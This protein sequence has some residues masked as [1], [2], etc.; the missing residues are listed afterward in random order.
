MGCILA[1]FHSGLVWTSMSKKILL[2]Q[3]HPDEFSYNHSLQAAYKIGALES[4]AEIKETDNLYQH[5]LKNGY[6]IQILRTK[7]DN[8]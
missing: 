1:N 3:G 6:T 2:I 5:A 4:G 7:K 8:I